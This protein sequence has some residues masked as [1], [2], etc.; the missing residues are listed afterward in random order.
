VEALYQQTL[1][2]KKRPSTGGGSIGHAHDPVEISGGVV[3]CHGTP[4]ALGD[5]RT[6]VLIKI[7]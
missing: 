7:K 5:T 2:E 4:W 3:G 6:Q 1:Y